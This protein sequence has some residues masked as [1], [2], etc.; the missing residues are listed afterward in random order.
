M[1]TN[2]AKIVHCT[3]DFKGCGAAQVAH[4]VPGTKPSKII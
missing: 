1:V 4:Q 2:V 3:H